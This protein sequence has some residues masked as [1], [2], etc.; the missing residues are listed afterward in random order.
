MA[1]N[2]GTTGNAQGDG[3]QGLD[4]FERGWTDFMVDIWRERMAMLK[5]NNTGA[6]RSSLE[7]DV[8]GGE[9]QRKISHKFLMY[10][11]YVAAGVG[12]GYKP[13]NGGDL[14]FLSPEY[15]K[16]HGLDKP[17]K[18]GP[19]WGGGM[20]S[21]KPRKARDWFSRKYYYSMRRLMEKE[22]Q[23]YGETYN[24][25]MIQAV[26]TL[27]EEGKA[28]TTTAAKSILDL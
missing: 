28:A 8:S 11:I 26:A 21:G 1:V 19:A 2:K 24:G 13:G 14:E 4:D 6:L 17:R 12:R 7:G 18:R 16:E 15:R 23:Y 5:I 25:L 20:T 27:F 9:G 10:G 22:A 3:K